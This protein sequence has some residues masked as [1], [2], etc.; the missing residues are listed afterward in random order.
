M[1]RFLVVLVVCSLISS[2]SWA[3]P[4]GKKV[5]QVKGQVT[6]DPL[7]KP[8]IEIDADKMDFTGNGGYWLKGNL[9][10]LLRIRI[11][12]TKL[13]GVAVT[14]RQFD[15]VAATQDRIHLSGRYSEASRSQVPQGQMVAPT[16]VYVI[17]GSAD[18]KRD[19]QRVRFTLGGYHVDAGRRTVTATV[20]LTVE[21]VNIA[22]GLNGKSFEVEGKA[23]MKEGE[24]LSV[25]E[26]R[27]YGDF[28]RSGGGSTDNELI[29][30]AASQAIDQLLAQF[31]APEPPPSPRENASR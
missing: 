28:A 4:R 26:W 5:G 19:D 12:E 24:R 30:L 20:H 22:T 27:R 21:Q 14:G 13:V 6:S 3:A 29:M 31:Q 17:T 25:A 16:E 1:K 23:S 7:A 8:R 2:Y 11:G 10:A 9:A 15:Q 18:V